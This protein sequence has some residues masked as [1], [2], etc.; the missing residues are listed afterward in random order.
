MEIIKIRAALRVATRED[1]FNDQTPLTNKMLFV[2]CNETR[3]FR[4]G[5]VIASLHNT[6]LPYVSAEQNAFNR[7][8]NNYTMRE[9]LDG[10][11]YQLF[12]VLDE[13]K[14]EKNFNFKLHLRMADDFDFFDGSNAVKQ[15]LVYY[16][17]ISDNEIQGPHIMKFTSECDH[18]KKAI[19][20]GKLFVPSKT[21][22][23]EPYKL[24]KAS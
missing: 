10:L 22:S 18:I 11:H 16:V 4:G 17:K 15:N 3:E 21:Q 13:T 14:N 9:L 6:N 1:I 19:E 2:Q 20:A 8:L 7:K 12:Y 23:F 5:Y 24:A